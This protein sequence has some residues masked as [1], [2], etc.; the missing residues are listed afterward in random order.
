[1]RVIPRSPNRA[2]IVADD[3]AVV[4]SVNTRG[5]KPMTAETQAALIALVEAAA[6]KFGTMRACPE[7]GKRT[8]PDTVHTC[9]PATLTPEAPDA[10]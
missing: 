7:C 5:C 3:G 10:R 9:S 1:M 6:E 2:Q 4:A 8:L